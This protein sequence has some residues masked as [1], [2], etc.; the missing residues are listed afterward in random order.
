MP[1]STAPI[2]AKSVGERLRASVTYPHTLRSIQRC[3]RRPSRSSQA[4]IERRQ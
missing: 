3:K 1:A 4:V 2:E